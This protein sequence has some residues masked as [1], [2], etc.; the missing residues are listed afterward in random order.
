MPSNFFYVGLIRL[1][2][3]NARIIHTMRDPGRYLRFV[4]F[5]T[6][7]VAVCRSATTWPSWAV[8]IAG[9]TS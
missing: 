9:I 6:V 3:P 2:L 5:K 8:F 4:F 1:I 7:R